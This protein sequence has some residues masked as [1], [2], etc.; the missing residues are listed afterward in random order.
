MI[1]IN[2][3]GQPCE[4]FTSWQE[5][6][7][8]Q[9]QRI[10]PHTAAPFF[11]RLSAHT[12]LS[13]EF[14]KDVDLSDEDIKLLTDLMS[15]DQMDVYSLLDPDPKSIHFLNADWINDWTI[16]IPQTDAAF[17]DRKIRVPGNA[18]IQPV[19]S[20]IMFDQYVNNGKDQIETAHYAIA[21]YLQPVYFDGVFDGDQ[22]EQL[23]KIALKCN[24][25]E[26]LS[27]AAFFL[28]RHQNLHGT[29]SKNLVTAQQQKRYRQGL[30]DLKSSD[31]SDMLIN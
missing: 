9:G 13:E 22:V 19:G 26:A 10:A 25:V 31:F 5:L 11:E 4:L 27:V 1:K 28:S 21:V 12:G 29:R 20:K 8:E 18:S 16:R 2:I 23:A 14:L 17:K 7:L 24:F 3:G 30:T 6:T 15:W